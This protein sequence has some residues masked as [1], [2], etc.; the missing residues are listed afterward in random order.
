MS[1]EFSAPSNFEGGLLTPSSRRTH[2]P[3]T[4]GTIVGFVLVAILALAWKAD[5]L[6][7]VDIAL[8]RA[9]NGFCGWSPPLDR[10]VIHSELLTGTLFMGIFGL[11]WYRDGE[12]LAFRRKTLIILI[13]TVPTSLILNRALSTLLPFRQRPM[14]SV[15]ANLPSV[16]WRPDMENWSSFPSD[17]GSYL[18]AIAAGLWLI[19]RHWG[20][21]FG[22]FGLWVGLGRVFVGLHY[23]GDILTGALIGIATSL[24]VNRESIRNRIAAPIIALEPRYRAYFYGLLFLTLA[25]LSAGFPN[26][27]HAG[28]AVVHFFTGYH[29]PGKP[30]PSNS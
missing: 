6:T 1:S 16:D 13:L 30:P 19:S 10:L 25:E 23:P 27:R 24:A 22:V 15:G 17:H 14:Y 29:T 8:F 11:L 4:V 7:R 20:L 12:G 28:V 18:F 2:L 5:L 21:L 3:A 9:V 26:A